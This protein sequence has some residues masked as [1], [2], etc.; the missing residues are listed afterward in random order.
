M[1]RGERRL[2]NLAFIRRASKKRQRPDR[3]IRAQRDERDYKATDASVNRA[4]RMYTE[5][6]FG[7]RLSEVENVYTAT[8]VCICDGCCS[9]HHTV[10]G[11]ESRG[12][13]ST[14][15]RFRKINIKIYV[16]KLTV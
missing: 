10:A 6:P 15:N 16:Y 13:I 4:R 9:A 12:Q 3:G 5:L 2:G 8:P 11:Q 1:Y 7:G 14:R